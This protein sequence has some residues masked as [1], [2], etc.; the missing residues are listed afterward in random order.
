MGVL[1]NE[2]KKKGYL[3]IKDILTAT[4]INDN[5][6][7]LENMSGLSQLTMKTG[8]FQ[9]NMKDGVS[10]TPFFWPLIFHEK[11]LSSIREILDSPI[12][13]YTEQSDLKVWREQPA[14]GWHRDSVAHQFGVG[15]EW[16]KN[17]DEYRVVRVAFYLQPGEDNFLWGAYPGSHRY[18][19]PLSQW[20]KRLWC[21]ILPP[22][23]PAI[24]SRLPYLVSS[25]GRLWIR[26][27]PLRLITQPPT[28]PHWLR[29][30]PGDC[31][32]FDPRLIHAGGNVTKRKFAAFVSFSVDNEHARKHKA[33]HFKAVQ[34]NID[35]RLRGELTRK[36]RDADLLL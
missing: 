12:I 24:N 23:L 32:I 14:S 19:H 10:K 1:A 9:W 8:P 17:S 20:E 22:S 16:S 4:E 36:L 26:T 15:T 7:Y 5:I 13:R 3:V 2:F 34:N 35:D 31:I 6:K 25:N 29:T 30:K 21:L 27:Q 18:E 33:Y 11:L 28:Q